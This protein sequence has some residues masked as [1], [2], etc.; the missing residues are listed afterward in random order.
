[1]ADQ[2]GMAGRRGFPA[3]LAPGP[4]ERL[5]LPAR[6]TTVA[7][8]P[9]GMWL[10]HSLRRVLTRHPGIADRL[11]A[12]RGTLIRIHP[13]ELPVAFLIGLDAGSGR[14]EAIPA[15]SGLPVTVS[16]EAPISVLV[17]IFESRGDGDA[18][19]FS[20]DLMI[21]GEVAPLLS[22]RNAI[23]AADLDWTD[24]L[25]LPPPPGLAPVVAALRAK[26]APVRG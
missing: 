24:L 16:V 15:S 11:D 21:E 26:L 13:R 14:V 5:R 20:A 6:F 2:A 7:L 19:L 8:A 9:L 12:A 1:M 3:A 4:F 10:T 25:P 22:L 17:T 23:E 18:A